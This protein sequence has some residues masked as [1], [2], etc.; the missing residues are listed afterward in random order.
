M[1]GACWEAIERQIGVT[2]YKI[3]LVSGSPPVIWSHGF[4]I[5]LC[6]VTQALSNILRWPKHVGQL[7]CQWLW[8]LQL[9]EQ[10]QHCAISPDPMRRSLMQEGSKNIKLFE[11]TEVPM[12]LAHFR[13]L[14][15]FLGIANMSFWSPPPNTV[16]IFSRLFH[17]R[18]SV[19][20][21]TPW[22]R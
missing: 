5:W 14:I 4:C 10:L 17:R 3:W 1:I 12:R 19:P 16:H 8:L 15:T 2:S 20:E 9:N 11:A 18:S 6:W 22:R 7:R 13:L 21:D